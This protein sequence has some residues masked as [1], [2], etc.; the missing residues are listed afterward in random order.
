M[1]IILKPQLGFTLAEVLITLG[2]IGVIAALT[3]P[4]LI[5]NVG[6]QETVTKVKQTY[7]TLTSMFQQ[8][9]VD[10]GTPGSV[11][12]V[13]AFDGDNSGAVWNLLKQYLKIGNLKEYCGQLNFA[14]L[15]TYN[16]LN[17]NSAGSDAM[18]VPN[19]G[20]SPDG[21]LPNG[22]SIGVADSISDCKSGP[23]GQDRFCASIYI[24]TNGPKP[25]NVVGKDEF[26]FD[27]FY[28][29]IFPTGT[30]DRNNFS[31]WGGTINE[32]CDSTTSGVTC[33]ERLLR[34]GAINYY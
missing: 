4:T 28:N 19:N 33:A 11:E 13:T 10:N 22:V 29:G 31:G 1:K 34:E 9:A 3:I 7:S 32:N 16:L 2:I 23:S 25:P 26:R 15:S 30:T 18:Y 17:G 20:C 5:N 21:V 27:I 8:M 12:D 24:D 14:T 6:K